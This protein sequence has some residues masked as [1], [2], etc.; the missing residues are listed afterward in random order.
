VSE[1]APWIERGPS[2]TPAG[3]GVR[4]ATD[5]DLPGIA[6]GVCELLIELGGSP[7][8]QTQLQDAARALLE[9]PRD[10]A[11]LV[12]EDDGELVGFLGVSW[13]SAIRIP[14]RYGLIQE[15]WVH[16]D[17]RGSGIGAELLA[18]LATLARE[19]GIARIEVGLPSERFAQLT[20]TEAFYAANNFTQIG[21]RMRRLL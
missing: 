13:Q 7:A 1:A 16:R 11:L 10:G 2:P 9:E 3:F 17:R 19:Q 14:G 18:T 21:T 15:L 4:G 5:A 20:A 12:A 6:V 8:P